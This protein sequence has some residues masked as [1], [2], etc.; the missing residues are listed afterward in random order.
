MRLSPSIIAPAP[1]P[2]MMLRNGPK[3]TKFKTWT[4]TQTRTRYWL[5]KN[6]LGLT[7]QTAAAVGPSQ[8]SLP[9]HI[10]SK[11]QQIHPT[12]HTTGTTTS[13]KTT[14]YDTIYPRYVESH[15]HMTPCE[16]LLGVVRQST[17]QGQSLGRLLQQ[18]QLCDVPQ[19][20]TRTSARHLHIN[21]GG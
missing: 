19:P 9:M 1:I 2:A 3:R 12:I 13:H 4:W 20:S 17:P 8:L 15:K 14:T 11:P 7:L 10:S 21:V 18:Q 5:R 6:C 16:S